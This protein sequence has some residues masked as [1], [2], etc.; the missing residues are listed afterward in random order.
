MFETLIWS[1]PAG[2]DL[3]GTTSSCWEKTEGC[4]RLIFAVSGILVTALCV[5]SWTEAKGQRSPAS[6]DGTEACPR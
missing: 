6:G 4:L 5:S 2:A 1:P 3:R